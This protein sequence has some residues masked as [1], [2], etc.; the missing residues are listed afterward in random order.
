VSKARLF[1]SMDDVHKAVD[2]GEF[3]DIVHLTVLHEDGCSKGR[4]VCEPEYLVEEGT[5]EAIARG[6]EA[7]SRWIKETSN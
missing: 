7:E 6:A 2:A 1:S 4:C 3:G 5:V